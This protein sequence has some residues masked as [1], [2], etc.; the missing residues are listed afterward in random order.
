MVREIGLGGLTIERITKRGKMARST[1][2]ELFDNRASVV[3]FALSLGNEKLRTAV[4]DAASAPGDANI[5]ME[6][7]IAALLAAAEAEPALTTLCLVQGGAA[8]EPPAATLDPELLAALAKG[9][10]TDRSPGYP[11]PV[12]CVDE[13]LAC[14][15]LS[16]I[17]DRLRQGE[18][19]R[20]WELGPELVEIIALA[21]GAPRS[22]S[23]PR[24]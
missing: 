2:Y 22:E 1:V 20:L 19:E 4:D 24:S 13:L 10:L 12:P 21:G 5:R 11:A 14:G 9:L 23:S 6:R 16:V 18:E 3:R 17:A 15:V 7:V 8:L